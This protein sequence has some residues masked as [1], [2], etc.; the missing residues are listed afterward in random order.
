VSDRAEELRELTDLWP[1]IRQHIDLALA[2]T[3]RA[4]MLFLTECMDSG[5]VIAELRAKYEAGERE[6]Q[7]DWLGKPQEW[8]EGEIRNE[9]RDQVLY[10]AMLR[11]RWGDQ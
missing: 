10:H 6:H 1:E 3:A 7:R 2:D 5:E 4:C 11:A 8:L 9:L